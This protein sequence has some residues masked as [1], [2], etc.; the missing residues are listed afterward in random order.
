MDYDMSIVIAAAIDAPIAAEI[1]NL[2]NRVLS[3]LFMFL[4]IK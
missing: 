2:V 3:Y 4:I 1:V